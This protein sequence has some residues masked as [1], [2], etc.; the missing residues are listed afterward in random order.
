MGGNCFTDSEDFEAGYDGYD[1]IAIA[2][3]MEVAG[4]VAAL[5]FV[6]GDGF[7]KIVHDK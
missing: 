4:K 1:D 3:L 5:A 7:S 6:D 2:V